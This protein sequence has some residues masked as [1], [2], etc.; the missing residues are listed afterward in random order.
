M[1]YSQQAVKDSVKVFFPECGK[2]TVPIHDLMKMSIIE[3][4]CF[5]EKYENRNNKT[6][7]LDIIKECMLELKTDGFVYYGEENPFN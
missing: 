2:W 4:F 5:P 7:A 3:N 1:K 6:F